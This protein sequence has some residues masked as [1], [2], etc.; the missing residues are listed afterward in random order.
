MQIVNYREIGVSQWF[1]LANRGISAALLSVFHPL[2]G[3][4]LLLE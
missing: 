2:L 4:A 1:Q 3:Y